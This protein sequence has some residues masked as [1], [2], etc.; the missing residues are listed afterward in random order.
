[1]TS[2]SVVYAPKRGAAAGRRQIA[3]TAI[4]R[5]AHVQF[6]E[7]I[8]VLPVPIKIGR[9]ATVQRAPLPRPSTRSRAAT[10]HIIETLPCSHPG[11]VG[12]GRRVKD[13]LQTIQKWEGRLK[14][15]MHGSP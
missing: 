5:I 9:F 1:M 8:C 3:S 11:V 12:S 7:F 2:R 14:G 10:I 15:K 13:I 6:T 4:Y